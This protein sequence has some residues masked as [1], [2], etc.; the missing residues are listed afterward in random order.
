MRGALRLRRETL[1]R[2]THIYQ[3][4]VSTTCE[5]TVTELA[6][7]KATHWLI[8]TQNEF[9][10]RLSAVIDKGIKSPKSLK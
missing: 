1:K 4:A 10:D 5:S 3:S 7:V 2:E 6:S 8:C 9:V